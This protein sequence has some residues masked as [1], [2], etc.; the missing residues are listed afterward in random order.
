MKRAMTMNTVG[1]YTADGQESGTSM[2]AVGWFTP[3]DW[4]ALGRPEVITVT[5]EAG[6][7][8]QV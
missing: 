1:V 4:E 3:D 5:V 7:T 8:T 2:A 6:D